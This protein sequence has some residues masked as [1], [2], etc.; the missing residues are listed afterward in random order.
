M[1]ATR[2]FVAPVAAA[3]ALAC[4][5]G[6]GGGPKPIA[7][8]QDE[9]AGCRMTLV[10]RHF[11]AEIVTAKGK[12]FKFDDISCLL[13]FQSGQKE[14]SG[15]SAYVVDF[16]HAGVLLRAGDAQFLQHDRLRSPMGSGI[17][18]F[19]SESGLADTHRALNGGGKALRWADLDSTH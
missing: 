10:D 4:I 17:A 6:C 1:T 13:R 2:Q 9:C 18:A 12:V 3:L 7:Y 16:D 11:G 8:G 19:A 14:V 5:T 15:S